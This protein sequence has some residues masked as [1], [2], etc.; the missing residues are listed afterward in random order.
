MAL[1]NVKL[2]ELPEFGRR[3]MM[4]AKENEIGSPIQLATRLYEEQ[5]EL[6]EPAR[7]KN[8][9]GKVVKDKAHD[10]DAIRRMVQTHF[11]EKS[12]FNVQSK[13]LLA[14]SRIFECSLD[15]LYGT[16]TVRSCDMTVR[17]ICEKLHIDEKCVLNLLEGYDS[18]SET[19]SPTKCWTKVLSDDVFEKIPFDWNQYCMEKLELN[20]LDKKIEA[21]KKA[22]EMAEDLV[23]RGMMEIKRIALEKM[24]PAK[25]G[26]CQ[27][28]YAILSETIG[29]FVDSQ[30]EQWLESMHI[31]LA[32]NYYD[33]ELK[34]IEAL[35][36]ALKEGAKS[37]KDVDSK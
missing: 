13:Y 27:G 24:R 30:T 5:R 21:I 36:A 20:D 18:N 33:N 34:K 16:T 9:Y 35:K 3:L 19:F 6:V 37:K 8:K 32:D 17:S 23:Y 31:D 29:D 15:Y 12:A 14:Y 28:A 25:V 26:A 10:I 11:N 2:K 22:E 4:L 7:R 1:A